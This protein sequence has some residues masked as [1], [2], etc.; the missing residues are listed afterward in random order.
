MRWLK[1]LIDW[2]GRWQ[3][4][5]SVAAFVKPFV[6]PWLLAMLTGLTGYFGGQPWMWVLMASAL[7]FMGT[8]VGIFYAGIY[9]DRNSPVNKVLYMGTQVNYDLTPL[10]RKSRRAQATGAAPAR[11]IDKIQIGVALHNSARFPIE[12]TLHTA[13]TEMEGERPPRTMFPKQPSIVL[14]SN[15][16]FI[17]DD[18]IDMDGHP[19]E[20]LEGHMALTVK[21]GIPGKEKH[22]LQFNGRVEALMRPEGFIPQ[23]YTHWDSELVSLPTRSG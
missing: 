17:M 9:R 3:V 6:W 8:I 20:K 19:C 13:E 11:T 7:A 21:Y 5:Q 10:P 2:L 23:V 1:S 22:E 14:P 16:V 18:P 12:V 4:V 15:T